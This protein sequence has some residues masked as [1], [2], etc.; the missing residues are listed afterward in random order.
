MRQ[1]T[2][3]LVSLLCGCLI[4]SSQVLFESEQLTVSFLIS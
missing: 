3:D 4:D 1:E 2:V